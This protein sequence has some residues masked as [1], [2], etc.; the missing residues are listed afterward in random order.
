MLP[1]ELKAF[2]LAAEIEVLGE[3]M[4]KRVLPY[5]MNEPEFAEE[6]HRVLSPSN[7]I[8]TPELLHGR[9][10]QLDDIRK[11][12]YSPGRQ[13]FIYGH[14]GVGKTSLAQTAAYQHQ[15]SD[16]FPIIVGCSSTSTFFSVIQD[17]AQE[18]FPPDPRVRASTSQ[19]S[20]SFGF[21]GLKAGAGQSV[22]HGNFQRPNSLN[23]AVHLINYVAENHSSSPVVIIDEFDQITD[24][25]EQNMFANLVKQVAD[26]RTRINII[27]C[28]VGGSLDDL[29][30]AH[31]SAHRYFHPIGLERLPYDARRE[32][33]EQAAKHLGITIDDT[34]IWRIAMIS[35]GF[36]HYVHLVGEKLFWR[37]FN[38]QNAGVV[39]GDLFEAALADAA[40]ALHP[41]IKKPYEK[42]T[43]KYTNACEPILWA[44]ADGDDLQRSSR[45]IW[46]SYLRI[47]GDLK[48][49]PLERQK[50]NSYMNALKKESYGSILAASRSGWYEF[51][52]KVVRGYAR[53]KALQSGVL[54]E[55][56]HPLQAK[57]Y[58]TYRP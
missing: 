1:L 22:E 55:R 7:A 30:S 17:I 27:F 5:R 37:V 18:A 26:K 9:T 52:N 44:V 50:F 20:F 36:P 8:Q 49:S 6:L 45:D 11:A 34:S 39:T 58:N 23:E 56:E 54:L 10:K 16:K 31:L 13:V 47:M 29:F 46:A 3:A 43:K 14:R 33:I 4:S 40:D 21:R 15:S 48:K 42:A 57:R 12:L 41:E 25:D 2:Y 38:E 28:G 35:D 32:I 24:R 19:K 51:S 53:L